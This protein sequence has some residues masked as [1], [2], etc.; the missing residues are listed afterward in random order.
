MSPAVV[1][2]SSSIASLTR[3]LSH[4]VGKSDAQRSNICTNDSADFRTLMSYPKKFIKIAKK[5]SV[6]NYFILLLLTD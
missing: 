6:H 5:I 4:K 1:L 3:T 2:L